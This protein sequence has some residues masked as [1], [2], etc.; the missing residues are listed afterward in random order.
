MQQSKA[1]VVINRFDITA[2]AKI[3]DQE[4]QNIL[5]SVFTSSLRIKQENSAKN[6]TRKNEGNKTN[7]K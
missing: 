1:P 3:H 2:T 5:Q 4:T 6:R 7:R